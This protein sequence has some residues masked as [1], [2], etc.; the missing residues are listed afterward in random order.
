MCLEAPY[1][2][3]LGCLTPHQKILLTRERVLLLNGL[4]TYFVLIILFY[5][6]FLKA[7]SQMGNSIV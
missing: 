5:A 4:S 7:L 6:L 2:I 3:I 1:L